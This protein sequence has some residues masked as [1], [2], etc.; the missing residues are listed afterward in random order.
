MR[1][2]GSTS[3]VQESI[4][5]VSRALSEQQLAANELASSVDL[6]AELSKENNQAITRV[7]STASD[8]TETSRNLKGTVARFTL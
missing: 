2:K 7:S 6:I 1:S 5:E 3:L 4:A 8:M